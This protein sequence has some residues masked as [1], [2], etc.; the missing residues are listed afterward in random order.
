MMSLLA[1]KKNLEVVLDMDRTIPR[2]VRGDPTRIRQILI[3]LFNN[4]V[5]FTAQGEIV[6]KVVPVHRTGH[7]QSLRFDVIDTGIGIAEDKLAMLFHA[8]TQVDSSTTRKYGGTGLGLSISKSFVQMMNGII[9]VS[10]ERGRGSDF[11]FTIPL[12]VVTDREEM[13]EPVVDESVG[14]QRVLL[15]D[16]NESSRNTIL[17]HLTDWFRRVD[18]A[19]SGAEALSMLV[20]AANAED[21]YH[22]ALVDLHLPTMDGW[23]LASEIKNNPIIKET[24]LFLM[25]PL[26]SGTEAKMKLLGW[27][28]GYLNKPIKRSELMDELLGAL[29]GSGSAYAERRAAEREKP[30]D[31]GLRKGMRILVAEDHP[32]NQQ[33]FRTILEK[34]GYAVH[35]ADN[36]LEAVKTAAAGAIDLVFMDVQMPEMNGYEAA[37]EIRKSGSTLPIIAVTANAL[38]GEREKCLAAGMNDFLTKP[39][40]SRDLVPLLDRWLPERPAAADGPPPDSR[41]RRTRGGRPAETPPARTKEPAPSRK[42]AEVFDLPAALETFMGKKDVV[43]RVVRAFGDKTGAQLVSMRKALDGKD[44]KPLEIESHGIKGGSWNLQARRLGNAAAELEAAAKKMDAAA[45]DTALA[46][47]VREYGVF[48]EAVASNPAL[49]EG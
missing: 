30:R 43:Q 21:P 6:I 18:T 44:W 25:S 3:N 31:A 34:M 45:A 37:G 20:D 36:G 26:G 38:K 39:F 33:L 19:A 29:S 40:K 13:V 16:D 49:R 5:K 2:W 23:H 17:G 12:E 28:A 24:R 48:R 9:D 1:H 14:G 10:T 11:W 42:D 46:A 4:A 8:F 35:L 41:P 15:V 32:V 7:L 27:F 22:F 47:V